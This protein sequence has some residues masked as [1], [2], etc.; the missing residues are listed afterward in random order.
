MAR[1]REF[2]TA[3]VLDRAVELFWRNGYEATSISDLTDHLG[4]GRASLYACF[5]S[6]HGLYLRA[7]QH[8]VEG[9]DSPIVEVLSRPGPVLPAVRA[10]LESAISDPPQTRQSGERG[11]LV[12]NASA[13]CADGDTAVVRWLEVSWAE[14]ETVLTSALMRARADGETGADTAP[15]SLAR[16]LVVLLQGLRVMDRCGSD[17]QRR[18][19]AVDAAMAA[20]TRPA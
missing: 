5:G 17:Q 20:L 4:I 8:Y 12:T 2:D 1:P 16:M 7:L 13:E 15:R 19:D 9:H 18:R 10:V 6:K 14:L 11:C 3:V